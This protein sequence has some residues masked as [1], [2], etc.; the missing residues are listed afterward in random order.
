MKKTWKILGSISAVFILL[1]LVFVVITLIKSLTY[2]GP[3]PYPTIAG[4]VN[5]WTDRFIVGVGIFS[6][7]YSVP[8]IAS[9][10]LLIVSLVKGRQVKQKVT[11]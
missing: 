1:F 10:I 8:L 9:V 11:V 2:T 3:Y 6:P 4:T 5:N 7:F